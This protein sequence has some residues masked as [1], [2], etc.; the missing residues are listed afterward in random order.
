MQRLQQQLAGAVTSLEKGEAGIVECL[1]N[2]NAVV[3]VHQLIEKQDEKD[4]LS[5]ALV[6]VREQHRDEVKEL[7]QGRRSPL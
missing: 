1:R 4:R 7:Q 3:S 5:I 6:G 2:I